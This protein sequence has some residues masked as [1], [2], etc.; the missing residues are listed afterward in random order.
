MTTLQPQDLREGVRSQ[1][2]SRA[3][4]EAEHLETLLNATTDLV[5]L[6]DSHGT[7]LFANEAM[8][9]SLGRSANELIGTNPADVYGEKQSRAMQNW[10]DEVVRSGRAVSGQKCRGGRVYAF[11]LSPL[12]DENG[13]VRQLAL[14]SHD[15]TEW[16]QAEAELEESR[17]RLRQLAL[18]LAQSME[19]GRK[20]LA[21]ELHDRVAQNLTAL[22]ISLTIALSQPASQDD[23]NL[24]AR[25]TDCLTIV[26]ET[27]RQIRD[28]MSELR[29]PVLDDYGLVAALEWY[30]GRFEARTGISVQVMGGALVPR[31]EHRKEDHLFR[32]AQEALANTA[33]HAEATQAMIEIESGNDE[34]RIVFSDNGVGFARPAERQE[35]PGWGLLTMKERAISMRGRCQ[36]RSQNPRGAVVEV[37]VPR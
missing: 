6:I 14:F 2:S 5:K 20:Q 30:A 37:V 12:P 21:Q 28:V 16:K 3:S 19:V 9:R 7:I 35:E 15:I 36:F 8:A 17:D 31:L 29:P 10:I 4:V 1:L 22:G 27:S 25:L 18:Q 23:G 33:K 11:R 32:I 34:I 26:E 24:R 13:R